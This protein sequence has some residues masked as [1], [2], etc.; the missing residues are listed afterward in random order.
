MCKSNS[1]IAS[2][3]LILSCA[4]MTLWGAES[5]AQSSS[6]GL[7]ANQLL[8]RGGHGG[9]HGGHHGHHSGHHGHH[10]GHHYHH[11]YHHHGEWGH[12]EYGFHH[13]YWYGGGDW[14]GNP[15]YYYDPN[16]YY[17]YTSVPSVERMQ[18]P[19]I[20]EQPE[21]VQPPTEITPT[22]VPRER[23]APGAV[24]INVNSVPRGSAPSPRVG[25]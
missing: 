12:H 5:V 16:Y 23:G 18:T 19:I 4:V 22:I 13:G 24:N 10:G 21:I 6:E 1:F 8:A 20:E 3:M 7:N 17:D 9:H 2:L 25:R 15:G 11:G 14:G